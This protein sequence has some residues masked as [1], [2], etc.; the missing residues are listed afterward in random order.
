MLQGHLVQ[1]LPIYS[2]PPMNLSDPKSYLPVTL[3][4]LPLFPTLL[5]SQG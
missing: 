5:A 2:P 4:N 3:K 1:V